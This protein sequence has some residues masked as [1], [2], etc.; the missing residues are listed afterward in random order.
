MRQSSFGANVLLS[1]ASWLVPAVALFI[2]I[3]I[4]V[5]GLGPSR[6]GLLV[7]VAVMTSYLGLMDMGLGAAIIRYVSHYRA[8]GEGR[9]IL[10]ILRF[11]LVWFSVA[12]CVG[13]VLLFFGA[14]WLVQDV[15]RAPADLW[16][17]AETVVRLTAFNFI[18]AMLL[19]VASAVPQGFLRYDVTAAVGSVFG[20][21]SA[22]GPAVLVTLGY[23]LQAIVL[24][25]IV[26]NALA[27]SVYVVIAV[28]LLRTV[29]LSVGPEWRTVRRKALSFAGVTAL[30]QIHTVVASQTSRLIVGL[31]GGPSLAAF[32]QVPSQLSGNVNQ[33]MHR[34]AAVLFPT[35]TDLMARQDD[36]AVATLYTRTSRLLFL[37]NGSFAMSLCVFAAPLLRYWVSALYAREG[38]AALVVFTLTQALNACTMASSNLVL[39]AGRPGVNLAFSLTNSFISLAA[40]YPLAIRYGVTGA[41]LAGLLGAANVPFALYYNTSH[42]L[43]VSS[44]MIWRVA[45]WP[46]VAGAALS[47]LVAWFGLRPLCRDLPSTLILSAL[48]VGLCMILSG[49]LGAVTREDWASARR[50]AAAALKRGQADAP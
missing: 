40:V 31:A 16:P 1:V 26:S 12:G 25:Y 46:T 39:S 15:L 30:N 17:T 49:L 44:W 41:A 24:F 6:Y 10:G 20:V 11:A 36:T 29:P 21:M 2:A 42:V 13:G 22:V 28:R 50:L 9:P 34:A 8:L 32:Y 35:G 38:A 47:V 5:R 33:M 18:L 43:K 23:G 19:S 27:L 37:I 14:A 3:P 45:Y 4:T 7:L 48:A